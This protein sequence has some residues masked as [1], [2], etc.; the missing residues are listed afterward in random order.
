[1]HLEPGLP[2]RRKFPRISCNLPVRVG[3]DNAPF[4]MGR[5]LDISEGGIRVDAPSPL[6]ENAMVDLWV[7]IPG[8]PFYARGCVAHIQTEEAKAAGIEFIFVSSR[9]RT[10]FAK[11]LERMSGPAAA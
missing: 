1:M 2:S 8:R 5:A 9:E 3:L 11:E 4:T 10:D 6:Y 7:D